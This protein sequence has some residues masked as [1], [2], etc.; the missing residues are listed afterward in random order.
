MWTQLDVD[1]EVCVY[2][3]APTQSDKTHFSFEKLIRY[4]WRTV[5][6]VCTMRCGAA[7]PTTKFIT[8]K[9]FNRKCDGNEHVELIFVF[10][11]VFAWQSKIIGRM[12]GTNGRRCIDWPFQHP[13]FFKLN[14]KHLLLYFGMHF[15][16]VH[17][18]SWIGA[19]WSWYTVHHQSMCHLIEATPERI[20]SKLLFY[21]SGI[22]ETISL[23]VRS[24][25]AG[26]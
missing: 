22:I 16:T 7:W 18:T 4:A 26:R 17:W 25:E 15:L 23:C 9:W 10:L 13:S 20:Y 21:L 3:C 6:G 14:P 12:G 11:F 24:A 19:W 1:A 8:F 2:V 5:A